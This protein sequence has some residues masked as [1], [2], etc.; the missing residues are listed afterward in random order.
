VTRQD[1]ADEHWPYARS[2]AKPFKAR[3]PRLRDEFDSAAALGLVEAALAFEPGR[4]AKFST[5]ARPRVVGRLRDAWRSHAGQPTPLP[6]EVEPAYHEPSPLD[7]ADALDHR[8]RPLPPRN[9]TVCRL[10]YRDGL[11]QVECG[12]VL[13]LGQH[14]I[15]EIHRES[16]ALLRAR[17]S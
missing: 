5:Y 3:L 16:L 12:R 1:L 13:G 7:L 15:N 14:R 8:L 9:R 10:I 4:G 2:L 17:L 6:L 11:T